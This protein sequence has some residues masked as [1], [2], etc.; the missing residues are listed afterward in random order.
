MNKIYKAEIEETDISNLPESVKLYLSKI[1]NQKRLKESKM[2]YKLLDKA[3]KENGIDKYEIDFHSK[4]FIIGNSI[5]F[6]ISHDD[7]IAVCVLSDSDI[8][9]DVMRIRKFEEKLYSYIKHEN[10]YACDDESFTK[11]WC[12]KE[13]YI[14][15]CGMTISGSMNKIDTTKYNYDIVEDNDYIIAV[16]Y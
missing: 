8:G 6:N 2:G 4:P 13:A 11:L 5:Q 12:M 10:E 7:G 1:N 16:C 15:K 14:K 9:I 3:L